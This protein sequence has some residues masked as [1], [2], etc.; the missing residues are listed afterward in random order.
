MTIAPPISKSDAQRLLVI[1]H[2]TDLSP[3][4][5]G[6][7]DDEMPRDVT[8]LREGLQTIH[9][10]AGLIHCHDGGAPFRFLLTQAALNLGGFFEFTGTARLEARP[11]AALLRAL[12]LSTHGHMQFPFEVQGS[13]STEGLREFKVDGSAS[14]QFV[15]SLILGAT[16][17]A[18]RHHHHVRVLRHG[19]QTSDGYVQLTVKLLRACGLTVVSDES[20]FTIEPA[21][22]TPI[23]LPSRVAGDWSSLT[24]LLPAAWKKEA[25]VSGVQ[26]DSGHP[27]ERVVDHLKSVGLRLEFV[28]DDTVRVL[29]TATGSLD[30]DVRECP[31]A[32][33]ALVA[34][35]TQLPSP[36]RF[37]H[38]DI[39]AMKE[40]DRRAGLTTILRAA[41]HHVD[42]ADDGFTV[43]PGTPRDFTADALDDHRLAMSASLLALLDGTKLALHGG[44]S[45]SKSFP[46]FFREFTRLGFALREL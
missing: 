35:A 15:S 8:V 27:D 21:I 46:H 1:A 23:T 24:I 28:S 45:V 19:A 29:G 43:R 44:A 39:L 6:L 38:T 31:D 2:A 22:D 7:D 20:G 4:V 9:R 41:G 25:L 37:A 33:P 36:S 18:Q 16:T 11:H 30:V 10:G 13:K 26:F 3:D 34:L 32:I 14:S 42:D 17:L 40:S 12:G 5:L